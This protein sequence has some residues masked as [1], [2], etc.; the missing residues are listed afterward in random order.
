MIRPAR[1][2]DAD[3]IADIWN[4]IIHDTTV[5]FTTELKTPEDIADSIDA[6]PWFV[7]DADDTILGFA[8][9]GPF[10]AGPGYVHTA[11]HSVHLAE[12]ARGMGL[13]RALL[14]TCE[15]NAQAKGITNLIA[16]LGHENEPGLAFHRALGFQEVGHL[17]KVG[18]KFDRWHDLVLM[19]KFL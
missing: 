3:Q 19:Q 1:P 6:S 4:A 17:P 10:R 11:E 15:A 7:A 9:Y 14:E 18:Y 2:D 16:G 8:T 13:G 12:D 5:T